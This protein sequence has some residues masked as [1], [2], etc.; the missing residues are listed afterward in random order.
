M[1]PDYVRE[2]FLSSIHMMA[3]SPVPLQKRLEYA[4]MTFHPIKEEDLPTDELKG[5]YRDLMEKLTKVKDQQEGYVPATT[6]QMT[7]EEAREA[8]ELIF[9][10]FYFNDQWIEDNQKK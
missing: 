3:V 4:Y 10:I 8:A 1:R 6:R 9:N 7:D 5:F 2:K